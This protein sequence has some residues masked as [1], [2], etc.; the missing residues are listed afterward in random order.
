M[1]AH[2]PRGSARKLPASIGARPTVDVSYISDSIIVLRQFEV[3]GQLRRCIAAIKKRQGE[4]E[5]WIRELSFGAHG[6]GVSEEPVR[7]LR[8]ILSGRPESHGDR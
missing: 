7:G 5:T 3:D 4:H 2:H 1:S 8:D 6:F